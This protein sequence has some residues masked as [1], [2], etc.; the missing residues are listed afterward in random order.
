VLPVQQ[1]PQPT[2][3][4]GDGSTPGAYFDGA[5]AFRVTDSALSEAGRVTQPPAEPQPAPVAPGAS[6]GTPSPGTSTV[7]APPDPSVV[8]G[9]VAVGAG[10]VA[11]GPGGSE[12]ERELVVG[13]MLYTVSES[14]IMASDLTSFQ[15]LTWMAYS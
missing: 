4:E 13:S 9:G 6:Q 8:I 10:A 11:V 1:Q 15:P 5:V 2:A 12:I 14:G 7:P 3:I